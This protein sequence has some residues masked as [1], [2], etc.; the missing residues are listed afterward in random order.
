MQEAAQ[1]GAR[2][3][4]GERERAR[5]RDH[6]AA[7]HVLAERGHRQLLGELRVLDIRA[8]AAPADE[9]AL[10][11]ELVEGSADGQP[12]D[13]EIGAELTLGRDRRAD[14]ELLDQVEHLAT[15]LTL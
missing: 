5:A 2:E 13:A 8:A 1:T 7:A 11:G 10:A 3:L 6:P 9:V 14:A 15:C 4:A 12:R